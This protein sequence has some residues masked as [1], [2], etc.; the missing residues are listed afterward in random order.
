MDFVGTIA[1]VTTQSKEWN[2]KVFGNIFKRKSNLQ[3]R[4]KGIQESAFFPTSRGLQVLENKLISELNQVLQEEE[5]LWFQKSRRLWIQDGDRNTSFYHKSTLIRRNRARIRMLKIDGEWNADLKVISDH[6][7]NFFIDLFDRRDPDHGITNVIYVG[8]KIN[9][10]QKVALSRRCMDF[11]EALLAKLAW[12]MNTCEDKLWVRIMKEKYVKA[13]NFFTAPTPLQSS[14]GW[15]SI[16]RGGSTIELGAAWRVGTG[17][18]LNFWSDWWVGD[19]PLGLHDNVSIPDELAFAKVSHFI[20]PNRSWDF[21]RLQ[22]ILPREEVN[23]I[24]SIP[25]PLDDLVPDALYWP[26]SPGGMFSVQE[27]YR[28]IAGGDSTEEVDWVWK[29]KTAER[30][31]MFLWLAVKNKLLTN[32]VRARRQLTDED[33]CTACRE[34]CESIDHILMHCDVARTC[35]RKTHTPTSFTLGAASP[36]IQW[37]KLNCSSKEMMNDV[38]WSLIFTCTCWELWKARNKRIFEHV[39]PSPQEIIRRAEF[40]ARDTFISGHHMRWIFWTRPNQGWVKINT[41]DAYKKGTGLASA[42]GLARDHLGDWLYGFITKIGATN[43]FAAELWGL[44]EGLRLAKTKGFRRVVLEMDSESV[45]ALLNGDLDDHECYSTLIKDCRFLLDSFE[46]RRL[47]HILREGNKCADHLANIGQ[48]GE[49]GTVILD[50]PPASIEVLLAADA[51]GASSLRVCGLRVATE[52]NLSAKTATVGVWIDAGS[53][54]KIDEN[55]GVAHF[56]EHMIFKGTDKPTQRTLEEEIE[57]MGG[58]LNAYT[59]REMTTYYAKVQ[60]K[61]VP[62]ALDLLSDIL[63]NSKFEQGN[64]DRERNVILREMEEVEGHPEEVDERA[65]TGN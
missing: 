44:R 45:V 1:E 17:D 57:N 12:Q 25:N 65:E 52:S 55:N 43:S 14:W 18:S 8:P 19:K 29:V 53:R 33:G 9:H 62:Q 59:S 23:K 7:S 34:F 36:F 49:W 41:D 27:A 31:R 2:Q 4:I 46:Q 20:L 10:A 5:I 24:R 28:Y 37:L 60:S 13:G 16:L 22:A 15:R 38:P 50:S 11:N 3:A 58:H 64:I 21:D 32:A 47:Q 54:F 56:L 39:N 35:W 40:T 51:A 63:Q 48:L 26:T 30:C 6:L 42:G 61:D